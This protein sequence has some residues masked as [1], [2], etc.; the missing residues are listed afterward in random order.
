M[1][2][3][4]PAPT[5][6]PLAPHF[7]PRLKF[8]LIALG[9]AALAFAAWLVF[10]EVHQDRALAHWDTYS[11]LR[12]QYEE[13]EANFEPAGELTLATL[14]RYGAALE[15][16]LETLK[17]Q[18]GIGALE[19][20]VRWRIVRNEGEIL[21]RMQDVLDVT[22]RLPHAERAL[23]QL[24]EIRQRFPDFP[25]NWG[26]AFAPQGF[27]NQTRRLAEW[28]RQNADWEKENLP[29]EL[30]AEPDPVVVLRTT[31]GDLRMGL[32][33]ALAPTATA[34]L[35]A[36]VEAG[37]Y[38]GTC[39]AARFT[40]E[41]TG[42]TTAEGVRAGDP[43]TR[44]AKPFDREGHLTFAQDDDVEHVL[45]DESRNRVLH[46][47]GVVSAWRSS[48]DAYDHPHELLFLARDGSTMNYVYTPLGRLL[49]EASLA[50]LDRIHASKTWRDDPIVARDTGDLAPLKD[51]L[52]APVVIVKA[53]VFR[54][55]ALTAS[56][57]APLPTKV[58]A[59]EDEKTLAGLK[60]DAYRTEP[61]A[62]PATPPAPVEPAPGAPVAPPGDKP[63]SD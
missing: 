55:G 37:F 48:T 32:Y 31:R 44:N 18:E 49:D 61:P 30:P 59:T 19:P 17:N 33:G 12:G 42:S 14:D 35:L 10:R 45:P 41:S 9:V 25:L 52:K 22:K 36:D 57:S 20:Q 58:A 6:L 60:P 34:R 54:G 23:Q 62:E 40:D 4:S 27:A 53:L 3:E 8:A 43:R 2:P 63:K 29:R 21:L 39:F 5:A 16:F 38:D 56:A 11:T 24:E 26:G 15:K 50:T 7:G 47:R 1:T 46:V 13:P 51:L 28:F